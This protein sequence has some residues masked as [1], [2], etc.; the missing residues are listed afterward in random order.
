MKKILI[1][2]ILLLVI[3]A[4]GTIAYA[5]ND[6]K[7]QVGVYDKQII[8]ENNPFVKDGI[9]YLPLEE[10]FEKCGFD[11]EN[12]EMQKFDTKSL[13]HNTGYSYPKVADSTELWQI[14]IYVAEEYAINEEQ[15]SSVNLLRIGVDEHVI[16]GSPSVLNGAVIII[17]GVAFAPYK[18]FQKLGST[19]KNLFEDLYVN[20]V[21]NNKTIRFNTRINP[22]K[23]NEIYDFEFEDLV[24]MCKNHNISVSGFSPADFK[25]F[26]INDTF[27]FNNGYVLKMD[28][29]STGIDPMLWNNDYMSGINLNAVHYYGIPWWLPRDE[30]YVSEVKI[31]GETVWFINKPI[32]MNDSLYLPLRELTQIAGIQEYI[33]WDNGKIELCLKEVDNNAGK[34]LR[35]LYGLQ[36]GEAQCIL[37]PP[38]TLP[39]HLQK[40]T[41]TKQMKNPP[42][43]IG[44]IT[45]IPFEYVEYMI[46]KSM[47]NPVIEYKVWDTYYND[48]TQREADVISDTLN[49]KDTP[50]IGLTN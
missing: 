14:S 6:V 47:I 2:C 37:N 50:Q 24:F 39:E 48:S 41:Q 11:T 25:C 1:M 8:F 20:A 5:Q 26:N 43:L 30:R 44:E 29:N 38:G 12:I 19:Y 22:Y 3:C 31:D 4:T 9:I 17:D 13:F 33:K 16:C 18:V 27:D 32:F 40:Y 23:E 7:V 46:N 34:E 28:Q 49:Y 10:T 35:Y 42:V 45:Y 36:I 15:Y 21:Y